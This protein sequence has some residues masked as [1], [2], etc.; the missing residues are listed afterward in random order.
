MSFN[1]PKLF[2]V[3]YPNVVSIDRTLLGPRFLDSIRA[4]LL[5]PHFRHSVRATL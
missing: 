2:F 5:G 1:A 3:T 4:T